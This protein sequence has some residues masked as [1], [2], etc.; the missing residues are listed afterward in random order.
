MQTGVFVLQNE[1]R[2]LAQQE[3][4]ELTAADASVSCNDGRWGTC[5][6]SNATCRRTRHV[7]AIGVCAELLLHEQTTAAHGKNT[8]VI[9]GKEEPEPAA[10]TPEKTDTDANEAGLLVE[11]TS[12]PF[13]AAAAAARPWPSCLLQLLPWLAP[14]PTAQA[15]PM[16]HAR[17]HAPR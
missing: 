11:V 12:L 16:T 4:L 8:A 14:S 6:G 9:E 1:P 15:P 17:K 13:F 2:L 10:E 5:D 7:S 3:Q